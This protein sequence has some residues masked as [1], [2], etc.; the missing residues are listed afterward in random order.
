V[1]IGLSICS[2]LLD[3]TGDIESVTRGL[4]DSESVVES[5][6]TWNGTKAAVS[7]RDETKRY[8][9]TYTITRHI[10]STAS[11]QSPKQVAGLLPRRR[12]SLKPAVTIRAIMAATNWPIPC[13]AKTAFI[14]APLHFV[15]ANSDVIMEDNG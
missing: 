13:I 2:G 4:G 11:W 3:I 7:V 1:H 5:D 6:T 10:L 14:I 9:I 8:V 12:D 15:V